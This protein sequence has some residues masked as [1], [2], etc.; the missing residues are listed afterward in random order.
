MWRLCP[1][2]FFVF[3]LVSGAVA[4]DAF[5]RQA[6]HCRSEWERSLSTL[7]TYNTAR[8]R[9]GRV[10]FYSRS[11]STAHPSSTIWAFQVF[12]VFPSFIC[13]IIFLKYSKQ[14]FFGY[15]F[16]SNDTQYKQRTQVT[17]KNVVFFH[18]ETTG[19]GNDAEIIQIAACCRRKTFSVLI[20][21]NGDIH[22]KVRMMKSFA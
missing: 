4:G 1:L 5:G 14:F 9:R 12:V 19:F 2:Q 11:E 10:L 16:V 8:T 15:S 18:L 6:F 22:P 17:A 7:A 13:C 20:I 3:C 21:P